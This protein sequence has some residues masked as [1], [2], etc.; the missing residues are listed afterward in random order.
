LIALAILPGAAGIS[1]YT[2]CYRKHY[3]TDRAK[4]VGIGREVAVVGSKYGP[5]VVEVAEEVSR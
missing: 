5:T 3:P 4:V 2:W 1:I